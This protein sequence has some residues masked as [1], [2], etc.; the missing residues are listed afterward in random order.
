MRFIIVNRVGYY[1]I[2]NSVGWIIVQPIIMFMISC[3]ILEGGET[4]AMVW[5]IIISGER[6]IIVLAFFLVVMSALSSLLCWLAI[7]F[8]VLCDVSIGNFKAVLPYSLVTLD[9]MVFLLIILFGSASSHLVAGAL[10]FVWKFS[11]SDEERAVFI[12][13]SSTLGVYLIVFLSHGSMSWQHI[14]CYH[15]HQYCSAGISYYN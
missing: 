3:N 6:Y 8:W 1:N 11:S 12:G 4:M 14:L 5:C 10:V 2:C 7:G 13:S 15:F 9:S